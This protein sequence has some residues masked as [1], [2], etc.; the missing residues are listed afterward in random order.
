MRQT[1]RAVTILSVSIMAAALCLLA[2]LPRFY[3]QITSPQVIKND[4]GTTTTIDQW[5][6]GGTKE[7][8]RDEHGKTTKIVTKDK[9]GQT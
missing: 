5:V 8:T 3:S 7:T 2:G 9:K 4:D 6:L 1:N